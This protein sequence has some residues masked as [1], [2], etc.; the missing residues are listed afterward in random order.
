METQARTFEKIKTYVE[1]NPVTSYAST[2]DIE[3]ISMQS[4]LSTVIGIINQPEP[5]PE[6]EPEALTS[7]IFDGYI[8]NYTI[9]YYALTDLTYSNVI[10][11]T[12]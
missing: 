12:T 9:K 6:P 10:S 7:Y 2:D 1:N 4:I 11:E 3:N 8:S 5:Q